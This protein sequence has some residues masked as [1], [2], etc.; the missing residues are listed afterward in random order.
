MLCRGHG[1]NQLGSV[2][3]GICVGQLAA[4]GRVACYILKSDFSRSTAISESQ[5]EL[6]T[7][8]HEHAL[9]ISVVGRVDSM[10]TRQFRGGLEQEIRGYNGSAIILDFEDLSYISS[11][12][13]RSILLVAEALSRRSKRFAL[14]SLPGSILEII[15]TTGF[16]NI[17]DVYMSRSSAVDAVTR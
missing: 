1:D 2:H 8:E 3:V 17:I 12:G 15:Q 13:L 7:E 16:D 6:R 5:F 9:V 10:N 11:A 4:S 14:C